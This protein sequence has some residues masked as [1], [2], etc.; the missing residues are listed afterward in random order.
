MKYIA[1]TFDDGRS[2]N[3]S[4]AKQ[5]MDKYNIKGSIY[6]TTG[7]ID[8]TWK[9]KSI[10]Q[11][12]TR[13]LTFQE[14]KILKKEGWEI[15]LHGDKHKAQVDDMKIALEKLKL[16]GISNDVWGLSVPNSNVT[17]KEIK[18]ILESEYGK[19][20]LYI[21]HGRRCNTSR[22]KYQI[23]F[24]M[25]S[26]FHF[27]WAYYYFNKKNIENRNE[28]KN[29]NISSIVIKSNDNPKMIVNFIEKIPENSVVVFMLHSILSSTHP[30]YKR[31]AWSWSEENFNLLCLNL[32]KMQ[33]SKKIKIMPL[34]E[35]IKKLE[36]EGKSDEESK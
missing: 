13:A 29:M 30:G 5:V 28:L 1:I 25:Y 6:I 21:R 11:S 31:D 15:G 17:E 26:I 16:W 18:E 23:L 9:E 8:N 4:V 35:I 3:Y 32:K 27:K 33:N 7:F 22:I 2:D 34:I 20:I 36:K 12:P 14:I 24:V 10:L 19:E